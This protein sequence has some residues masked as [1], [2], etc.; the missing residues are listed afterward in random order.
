MAEKRGLPETSS[1]AKPRLSQKIV[2][3][4]IALAFAAFGLFTILQER[5]V[6][7]TRHGKIVVTEGWPAI[8]MGLSLIGF[9]LVMLSIVLPARVRLWVLTGGAVTLTVSIVLAVVSRS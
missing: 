4:G 3:G 9:A 6:G 5:S 7:K 1:A 8:W 2:V